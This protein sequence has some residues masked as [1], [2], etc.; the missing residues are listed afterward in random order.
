MKYDI[1]LAG[2]GGQ[3]VLSLGALIGSAASRKGLHVKQSEVHGMAQRGGAVLAHLRISDQTIHSELIPEGRAELLLSMEPL[4]SLRYLGF[5]SSS[6]ILITAVDP[7]RNIP[8]YPEMSAILGRIEELPRAVKVDTV[9]LARLAG[10]ARSANMVLVGAASPFLPL[11]ES[12]IEATI[13]DL[14]HRKGER[15][16]RA[17]L[18][19]FRIG[20]EQCQPIPS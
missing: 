20:R 8:D 16:I 15:V 11:E 5:L 19:A 17:N 3:G 2:V 18:E 4:E 13:R 9:Q 14:F 10:E 12:D 6:G 7:V 1:V